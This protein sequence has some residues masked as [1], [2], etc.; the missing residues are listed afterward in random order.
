MATLHI[1]QGFIGAGKSTFSK[2]LELRTG[3]L[4]LNADERVES[5]FSAHAIAADWNSCHAQT[6]EAL[7]RE[8]CAALS[9]GKD[10][11]LDLGFWSRVSRDY[12]RA[13]ADAVQ[14]EILHYY[15]DTPDEILVQRLQQRQ[16]PIAA[17]NLRNLAALRA[18]FEAPQADE[19]PIVIEPE[20]QAT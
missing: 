4:R 13:Q 3:A 17:A 12:A 18:Q 5:H 19:N 20:E 7:W 6:V 15:I 1:I 8:T 2:K 14:A 16:G 10:V 11:I 9:S